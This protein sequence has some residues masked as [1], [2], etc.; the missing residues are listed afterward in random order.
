MS[1]RDLVLVGPH[2]Y[3]LSPRHPLSKGLI[4]AAQFTVTTAERP[5][6]I[7]R[8]YDVSSITTA[9][10]L[11]HALLHFLANRYLSMGKK[12]PTHI[13]GIE[14]NGCFIAAPLAFLLDLPFVPVTREAITET[15]FVSDGDDKPPAPPIGVKE[16]SIDKDSRVLIVD[17]YISS[18]K[19]MDSAMDCAMIAGSTIVEVVAMCDTA[20]G[21]GVDFI[22]KEKAYK[23]INV[24]TLF[25]LRNALDVLSY[26]RHVKSNY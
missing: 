18:G 21:G 8:P 12:G 24:I 1:Y 23:S 14:T 17:D 26:K 5:T 6:S 19:T 7:P 10:R 9:P 16:G 4:K 13:L 11:F 2:H 3:M 25:R 15:H 22:H 20:T